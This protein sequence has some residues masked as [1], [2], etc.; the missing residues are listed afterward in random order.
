DILIDL[1]SAIVV[2][3]VGFFSLKNYNLS[4]NKKHLWIACSFFTL[5]VAFIFEFLTNFTL[6]K[7]VLLTKTVG[8]VTATYKGLIPTGTLFFVG[9]LGYQFLTLVGLYLLFLL[10]DKNKSVSSIII[11]TYLLLISIYIMQLEYIFHI[12]SALFLILIAAEY[13]SLYRKNKLKTTKMLAYS[14]GIIALSNLLAM[15]M[16]FHSAM[17]AIAGFV[18]LVG[19]VLLLVTFITVLKNAKKSPKPL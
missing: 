9:M 17:H 13:V 18:Q 4:K 3:M 5:G 10:H 14:F 15:L 11:T 1:F 19:Y 7:T 8:L 16:S 2:L 6:Y 12:T